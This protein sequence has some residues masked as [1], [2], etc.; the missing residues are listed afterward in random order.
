MLVNRDRYEKNDLIR[1]VIQFKTDHNGKLPKKEDWQNREMEPSLRTFQRRTNNIEDLLQEADQYKSVLEFEEKLEREEEK[2]EIKEYKRKYKKHSK[3]KNQQA[4]KEDLP[5]N[6]RSRPAAKKHSGFQCPFCGNWTS[7][8]DEYYSS[9]TTILSM[10]FI[11]LLQ[12][13]ND[14]CCFNQVLDCI[15]AVFGFENSVIRNNLEIAGYLPKF[16]ERFG[17]AVKDAEYKL[18]CHVCG[19]LRD[20][21]DVTIDTFTPNA[22][23]I[24]EHCL[25]KQARDNP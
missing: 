25:S 23:Y 1:A 18:R 14:E 24:C 11:N 21:W 20:E 9:L 7:N 13:A 15:Y 2:K 12:S 16:E 3:S 10:R 8:V 5:K 17:K 6:R 22:E 4:G 19:E